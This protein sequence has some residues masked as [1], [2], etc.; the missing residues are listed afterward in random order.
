MPLVRGGALRGPS[1]RAAGQTVVRGAPPAPGPKPSAEET[2]YRSLFYVSKRRSADG[3]AYRKGEPIP[4]PEARRQGQRVG[5]PQ[6]RFRVPK[7]ICRRCE[8]R[9]KAYMKGHK[10]D[11]GCPGCRPCKECGGTGRVVGAR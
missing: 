7:L 9:G 11:C 2:P 4:E 10:P 1:P 6:L 3:N 8:G 5:E